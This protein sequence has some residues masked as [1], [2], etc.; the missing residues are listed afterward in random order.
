MVP[1]YNTVDEGGGYHRRFCL[2][3]SDVIFLPG[4]MAM[5]NTAELK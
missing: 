2:T 1:F 4:P 5:Y 3:P